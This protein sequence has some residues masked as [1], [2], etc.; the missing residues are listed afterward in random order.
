MDKIFI[1]YS[2]TGNG[3]YVS[4]EME[5]K[6]YVLRKVEEKKKMPKKFFF[7]IL[8]GGFRAGV[9]AKAKL[10]DFNNDISMFSDVVIG[11]PVWNGR[12]PPVINSVLSE[13][14]LENKNL[15]FLFYSGSG[16]IPKVNK[17]IEKLYPTAK[18]IVLKEPQ[19]HPDELSKI[20]EI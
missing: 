10:V 1:Y 17:K 16:T 13:I 2:L 5:K 6:G 4:L 12:F 11:S 14:N 20:S 3:D 15:T 18:V 7:R 8:A 9:G 19:T